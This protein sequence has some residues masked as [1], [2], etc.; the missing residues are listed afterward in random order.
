[1]SAGI[2]TSPTLSLCL[3]NCCVCLGFRFIK[4]YFDGSFDI[5]FCFV[6]SN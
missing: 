3:F 4:N 1:M 2:P 6:V 5:S